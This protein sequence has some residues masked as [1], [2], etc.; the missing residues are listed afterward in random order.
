VVG[1]DDE[2]GV[3]VEP[4]RVRPVEADAR[5]KVQLVAAE[6]LRLVA[7]PGEQCRGMAA[8]PR[9][10]QRR[11]VVDVER[12]PPGETVEDA[13]SGDRDG[14]TSARLVRSSRIAEKGETGLR[15]GDLAKHLAS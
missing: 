14:L 11:E 8:P 2:A 12:V 6:S 7:Q 15:S 1:G 4:V 3:Q 13:E 10:G 9:H 5:V